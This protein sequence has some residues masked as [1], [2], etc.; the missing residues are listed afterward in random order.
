MDTSPSN[1]DRN[2]FETASREE[3][4]L[5]LQQ[6]QKLEAI[7]QLAGGVAHDFNNMLTAI[8]GYTDLSL[9]RVGL[10]SPIRRHNVLDAKGG[11]EATSNSFKNHS[12]GLDSREESETC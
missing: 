9:R 7:G 12:P 5:Q 6:S 10:E 8:I 2:Y 11:E 3:I 4:L 1:L